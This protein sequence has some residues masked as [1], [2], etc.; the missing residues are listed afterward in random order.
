MKKLLLFLSL[1]VVLPAV[2]FCRD[3]TY[4]IQS[5]NCS[6]TVTIACGDRI[7]YSVRS[8]NEQVLLPSPVSLRLASGECWGEGSRV[9]GARGF[10]ID[11]V[12]DAPIYKRKQVEDRCNGITI[13]FRE[14]F[15]LE[16][17]AY[18]DGIA[19]RF[20]V[21]RPGELTVA[22][23]QA[24]FRFAPGATAF[25]P[26]VRDTPCKH[27]GLA[28]GDQFLQSFENTYTRTPLC[29][30]DSVR[31]AFLPLLVRTAG[32][33][34]VCMTDA[35]LESYPGM[36]LHR[37]GPDELEGVFA[38]VP[39][40]ITPGGYDRMQGMVEEYEPYI[41]RV[42]PGSR[43]PWRAVCITRED[44]ALAGNDLVWKL[45]SPCRLDDVSW[46]EPGLAAWEWW[47][48][49]GLSGVDFEAG[50]NQRTYEYYIDFASRN[51]LRY[52]VMD[53]GWSKDHH[54]PMEP[55]PALD[56]PALVKY[57]EERGVGLILWVG[58]LPFADRME[59][60]CDHYSKMGIKGFKVDFMDRDDQQLVGFVYDAA[61]TAARHRLLLDLHGIYKPTG[62][63]RT[64]PN[65]INFEGVHGLE[66]VKWSPVEVD[67]VT[68]DV[69]VPY[70]RMMAGPMDYTQGAM[71]N[72]VKANF[73]P[74][75]SEPMSQGTRCRQ[76][77]Q[78]IVF[79][80]PL[81]MLCDSPSAYEREPECLGFIAG[82]PTVWD[83]TEVLCGEVGSYI[84]TARCSEGVW[85][86]GGLAGWDGRP[87]R[88][89][90]SFLP[91]GAYSVELFRD[92]E[93][94]SRV[95][96]DYCREGFALAPDKSFDVTMAPG[97]GFA[98]WITKR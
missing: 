40:K 95:A 25:V 8:N 22:G 68:Y 47:N 67:Q 64:Y 29:R 46:I 35:D 55:A 84:V 58:Y 21:R 98:A 12:Y 54:S 11:A 44:T 26:Y 9:S 32:G 36:F 6:L 93:N 31:L 59:E 50:I 92:G 16:F 91:D 71:R 48:D 96:R 1:S 45:A 2:A 18:D 90:L 37:S 77:A 52:L 87:V 63:Q 13:D 4:T 51:G 53:D 39:R 74:V 75:N 72:A 34:N 27:E 65:V 17:R 24:R 62:I 70:I 73:R 20:V 60:L 33:V 49:W 81:G 23:E 66:Q 42:A 38:P 57:G 78:Y 41:A 30:M 15:S 76:L 19:Y 97:G 69:T 94:A 10:R 43:L 5:P 56:L 14:G 88:V 7:V 61:R 82:I 3:K 85:Y 28:F 79:D 80:A 86:V 83:R 89:D